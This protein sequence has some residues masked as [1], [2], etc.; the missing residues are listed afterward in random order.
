MINFYL[1]FKN[2]K[3]NGFSTVELIIAI[4][5]IGLLGSISIP[6]ALKWVDKEKQNAYVRELISYF[7]MVK[8]ETRRWNGR[9]SLETTTKFKND[10]DPLTNDFIGFQAFN[11]KCYGM[12]DSEIKN[13]INRVPKIEHRVFQEVNMRTFNFSPN[14][15]LSIPGNQNAFSY[16]PLWD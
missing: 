7:E 11:V 9:C 1:R 14:G 5:I 16:H 2:K 8:K 15:H 3:Q 13:I 6:T 4:V 10:F 12:N